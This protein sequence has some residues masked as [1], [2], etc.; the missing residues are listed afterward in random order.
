MF[1]APEFDGHER[2]EW[3]HDRRTGLRAIIALHHTGRGPAL[4][5]C[6][7][8]PYG[9][10]AEALRDVLRLSRGMSFKA[11]MACLPLGGGKAV[12]LGRSPEDKTPALLAA[13]GRAVDALGGHYIIA[14]DV[15][16]TEADMLRFR[17]ETAHVTGLPVAEGGYGDPSPHTARGVLAGIRAALRHRRGSGSLEGVRVAVQ[18]LGQV[19][20]HLCRLLADAGARLV[21]ADLDAAVVRRTVAELGAEATAPEAIYD[22]EVEVLAPCA[23]GAV[24]DDG[25]VG[26]LRAAI[27]AGAANNQLAEA[28]HGRALAERGILYA[29]DYVINAGGLICVAAEALGEARDRV[30]DRIDGIGETLRG[31]FESAARAGL[32]TGDMADRLAAARL[33]EAGSR[34]T[35]AA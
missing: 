8:W 3:I 11:A 28:R 32:P 19:G 25:T 14:E 27:V 15:G 33:E 5:G 13:M 35:L 24:L 12:I 10:G 4:G 16:M 29:P 9:S 23:L 18:G 34:Q 22:A 26:R 31:V 21:V 1:D 20:R 17:Q 2:V 6:R 30:D 7:M